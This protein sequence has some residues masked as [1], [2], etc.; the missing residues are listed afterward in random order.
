[1]LLVSNN[2]DF[3]NINFYIYNRRCIEAG[4]QV[5]NKSQQVGRHMMI[6]IMN[7]LIVNGTI[8]S[9]EIRLILLMNFLAIGRSGEAGKATWNSVMWTADEVRSFVGNYISL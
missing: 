3:L 1:M 4:L 7:S 8:A 5:K 6:G 2:N 9:M